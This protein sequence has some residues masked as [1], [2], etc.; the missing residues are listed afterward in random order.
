MNDDPKENPPKL[1]SLLEGLDFGVVLID[2]DLKI[3]WLNHPMERLF[4]VRKSDA[5][6]LDAFTFVR[7]FII[8]RIVDSGTFGEKVLGSIAS[9]TS[10]STMECQLIPTSGGV[11]WIEYSGQVIEQGPFKGMRIDVYQDITLKILLQREL[12]RHLGHLGEVIEG[13]NAELTKVSERLRNEM[14]ERIRA[15]QEL[16]RERDFRASLINS[17][18][19]FFVALDGRGRILM[20]NTPMLQSLGYKEPVTGM[21]FISTFVPAEEQERVRTSLEG[22]LESGTPFV[23]E[24]AVLSSDGRRIP[25]EWHHRSI[26]KPDGTLDFHLAVGI[27]IRE[28]LTVEEALRRSEALYRTIFENT[29]A[30]TVIL[31]RDGT[32]FRANAEFGRVYG[33]ERDIGG[34]RRIQELFPLEERERLVQLLNTVGTDKKEGPRYGEFRFLDAKG[35]Q[36]DVILSAARIPDTGDLVVSLL[37]ITERKSA[38][39]TR[40]EYSRHLFIMNQL[41]S[42]ISTADTLEESLNLLLEKTLVLLGLD[43]GAVYLSERHGTAATMMTQRGMPDWLSGSMRRISTSEIPYRIPFIEKRPL[44]LKKDVT[45]LFAAALIPFLS[46]TES[47]GAFYVISGTR[48]RFTEHERKILE[49]ISSEIGSLIHRNMLQRELEDLNSQANLYLDIMVH[50]I[51]NANTISLMYAELLMEELEGERRELAK[52]LQAGIRRSIGIIENVSTIRRIREGER[53]LGRQRLDPVIRGVIDAFPDAKIAYAGTDAQ[54]IAD[55]LL[56]EI[57]ANLISNSLKFGGPDT[58]IAISIREL[59]GDVE[60]SVEDNGPGIPDDLKKIVF[61]RFERGVSDRVKG[62]GLGLYICSMLVDRYGGKIWAED[63]IS[64]S[65]E[66]GLAIRFRLKKAV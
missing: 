43:A 53:R 42:A 5:Q 52:K 31:K 18:P 61:R 63:R 66:Q 1:P 44:Y 19:A 35:D 27:D 6:G 41:I 15:E 55:D 21:D 64:G 58:E 56:G 60:V 51:N 13:R 28:R 2:R 20:M 32:I 49:S 16:L 45:G 50:D 34:G 10:L 8:P 23:M 26:V 30:A 24:Y 62:S 37:D 47:I 40:E 17:S 22:S 38:E 25:C 54:V 65:S 12:E 9:G 36:R 3:L 11:I 7:Q 59:D 33:Y 39:R 14:V 46:K 4:D 48:E 29:L 57:F